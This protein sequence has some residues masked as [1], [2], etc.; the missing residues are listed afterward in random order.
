MK[1][2]YN[3][4]LYDWDGCVVKTLHLWLAAYQKFLTSR[5]IVFTDREVVKKFFG[6]WN[7]AKE[8]GIKDDET[9]MKQVLNEVSENLDNVKL[10][11]NI[12]EVFDELK[13][14]N[15]KIA[16][17]SSAKKEQIE[18][19]IDKNNLKNYFDLI[20]AKEDVIETKP[21]PEIIYKAINYFNEDLDKTIIIGDSP[22]D[23]LAGHNARIKT[24]IYYSIENKIF[25]D[26]NTIVKTNADY[27]IENHLEILNI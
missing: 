21:N 26:K 12:T 20:L 3:L 18:K 5:N 14:R 13:K 8:I 15:K 6:N 1:N 24:V 2:N 4:Y 16:I 7:G 27:V 22:H 11:E 25:Y 10:Y 9:Y 23:I 19:I 17:V